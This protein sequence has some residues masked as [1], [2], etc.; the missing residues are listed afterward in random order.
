MGCLSIKGIVSLDLVA[1]DSGGWAVTQ[2]CDD[3]ELVAARQF[4][5]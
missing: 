5:R 2:F 3:I 1:L 4:F